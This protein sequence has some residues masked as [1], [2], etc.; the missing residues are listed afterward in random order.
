MQATARGQGSE[1]AV[2][3]FLLLVLLVLNYYLSQLCQE[4]SKLS[5]KENKRGPLQRSFFGAEGAPLSLICICHRKFR[6]RDSMNFLSYK[7]AEQS[8]LN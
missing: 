2:T 4:L 7:Q 6:I 1:M 8:C 5:I 3:C